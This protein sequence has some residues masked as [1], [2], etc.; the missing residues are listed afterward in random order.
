MKFV[1]LNDKKKP[2]RIAIHTFGETVD[3][4]PLEMKTIE[5]DIPDGYVLWLK[6]W[7][8]NT[9]LASYIKAEQSL[10][11]PIRQEGDGG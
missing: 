1:Y 9:I 3:V 2:M 10:E 7:D 8:Y 4:Q 5:I 11:A 6:E